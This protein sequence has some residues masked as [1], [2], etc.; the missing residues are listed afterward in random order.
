[1][2]RIRRPFL[3][4]ARFSLS[5]SFVS[6]SHSII[7]PSKPIPRQIPP[8]MTTSL[9]EH[10]PKPVSILRQRSN[11]G[12]DISQH[13]SCWNI[14]FIFRS[15]LRGCFPSTCF[16]TS[17]AQDSFSGAMLGAFLLLFYFYRYFLLSVICVIRLRIASHCVTSP[18]FSPCLLRFHELSP[19]LIHTIQFHSISSDL[20]STFLWPLTLILFPFFLSSPSSPFLNTSPPIS[21]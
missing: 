18:I 12:P 10:S 14:P 19:L 21:L 5:S 15:E 4:L 6:H 2:H 7:I 20:Y 13:I 1:M 17:R 11:P 9:F 16:L 8:S 3:P